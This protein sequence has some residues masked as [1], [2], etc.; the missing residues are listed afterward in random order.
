MLEA[1]KETGNIKQ[2]KI[3]G[4]ARSRERSYGHRREWEGSEAREHLLL[5]DRRSH[6][7]DVIADSAQH[8]LKYKK[9][10]KPKT[11]NQHRIKKSKQKQTE[12]RPENDISAPSD[13]I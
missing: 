3:W 8:H 13:R 9:H 10:K 5:I 1:S 12:T 2:G 7:A 4:I 6:R 11:E